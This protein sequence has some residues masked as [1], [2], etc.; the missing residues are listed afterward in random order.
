MTSAWNSPSW[1]DAADDYHRERG[2]DPYIR[3]HPKPNGGGAPQ[4]RAPLSWTDMSR[5]DDGDPPPIE[6]SITNLV[7]REQVGLFSGVGGTGKTTTELLKDVAHVIGLPWFNWMPTQG[8]VFFVGCEDTDN[9]WRIR[10]TMIARA[11]Q[12]HVC[13]ADRRRFSSAQFVWSGRDVVLSLRQERPGRD[14]AALSA[15]LSSRR[16]SEADQYFA[17]SAGAHLCGQ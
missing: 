8:P 5:W 13:A 3:D 7:P 14:D 12:Y 15:N 1:K 10:L 6:W 11:L 17:R 9:V 2:D 16:R 4:N